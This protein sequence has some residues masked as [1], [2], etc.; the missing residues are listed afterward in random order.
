[1]DGETLAGGME[2]LKWLRILG[3]GRA[4]GYRWVSKGGVT[5]LNIAGKL[6]ITVEEI[7]R[8]W[9]RAKSGEFSQGPGGIC[10][11]PEEPEEE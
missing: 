10:A 8:F 4:T 5:P 9:I 6:Y 3:R 1:M 7:N 2:F 11:E